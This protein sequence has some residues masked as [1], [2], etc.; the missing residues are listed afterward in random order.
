MIGEPRFILERLGP[1][2]DRASF[3][4]MREPALQTYFVDPARAE[5][6]HSRNVA[7]IHVLVDVEDGR[8]IAGFFSL[9]NSRILPGTL[10]RNLERKLN[11][12]PDWG[13]LKLG[14]MARDDSYAGSAVGAILVARAF[15]IALRLANDSG[16]IALVV[17]AKNDRLVSWYQEL[18]FTAFVDSAR[19][20][21]IT[22]AAMSAY[23]TAIE[24]ALGEETRA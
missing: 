6:D 16:S 21:F 18:G 20:L 14:R 24:A 15:E 10:P 17:D 22:N 1:N 7:V 12:Y 13:A 2:H 5:R 19:T 8:K 9:S 23:L 4:C 11:R 3:V